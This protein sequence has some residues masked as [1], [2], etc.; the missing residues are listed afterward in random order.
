MLIKPVI[1][2]HKAALDI[3]AAIDFYRDSA[4]EDIALGFIKALEKA[5]KQLAQ[6]PETGSARYGQELDLPG[7]RSW[8]LK[9][10]PYL[11]F[12]I[13]QAD[14]LDVWRIL[15]GKTDIPVWMQQ[16]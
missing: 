7:L 3:D 13:E 2:R 1:P 12:Y 4:G 9:K 15:H 10:Y 5:F 11:I 16:D 8:P 6:H 14:H